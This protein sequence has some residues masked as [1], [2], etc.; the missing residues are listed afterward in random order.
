M[1]TLREQSTKHQERQKVAYLAL[2]VII[3]LM[4]YEGYNAL[5]LHRPSFMGMAYNLVLLGLWVWRCMYN[6]TYTITDGELIVER[7]GLGRYQTMTIDLTTAFCFNPEYKSSIFRRTKVSRFKHRYS[8]LDGNKQRLLVYR[9]GSQLW[10][11]IFKAGDKFSDQLLK[12]LPPDCLQGN[13]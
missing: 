8:S 4:G 10:G 13:I 2:A 3:C 9:H 1:A 7:Q 5:V 11:V 12:R 6:Y